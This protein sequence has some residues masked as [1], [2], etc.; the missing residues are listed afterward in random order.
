[1][2]MA[3]AKLLIGFKITTGNKLFAFNQSIPIFP[4]CALAFFPTVE[5]LGRFPCDQLKTLRDH[6]PLPV[7][8]QQMDVIGSD[9][10]VKNILAIT[11]LRLEQPVN[12]PL[13]ISHKLEKKLFL[14]APVR[15]VP[16]SSWNVMTIGSGHLCAPYNCVF[17]VQ[18]GILSQ[19]I[20]PK[21]TAFQC[22]T[23]R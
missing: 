23:V 10:V 17:S 7:N 13:T 11:L 6:L 9:A 2:P 14:M 22:A 18:M 21:I 4:K 12:P 5:R 8:D 20:G 19:N 1:M 3:F 16:D 15:N